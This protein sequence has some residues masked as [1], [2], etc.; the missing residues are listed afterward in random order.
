MCIRDRGDVSLLNINATTGAVTLKAPADYETIPSYSF[1]VVATD[2]ANTST[3]QAVTVAVTNVNEA[4]V[5]TT[6]NLSV[7]YTDTAA[8]DT[9]TNSTGIFIAIDVD[10]G[11]TLS[12]GISESTT[13]GDTITKVGTYGTF[14]IDRAS[15]A[16]TYTPNQNAIN[17][18]TTSA[19]DAFT[20]SVSDGSLSA[21]PNYIVNLV[22][23]NDSPSNIF[24]T[25]VTLTPG[26][27]GTITQAV[28]YT[29]LTLPTKRI[30]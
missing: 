21:T 29:H 14:S 12:Y 1:T 3:E 27:G 15:G 4:P 19:S 2:T 23:S 8:T 9:F 20:I 11:T 6:T 22:G 13:S 7:T 16:Y 26:T 25:S 30:V 24:N 5:F 18:L 17:A 10:A 28:S